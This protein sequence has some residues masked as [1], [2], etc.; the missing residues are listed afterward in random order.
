MYRNGA[1]FQDTV[2]NL[3]I[4]YPATRPA[5]NHL[6]K[7]PILQ[8]YTPANTYALYQDHCYT[9]GSMEDHSLSRQK[10]T[11]ILPQEIDEIENMTRGQSKYA[12]WAE[13]RRMRVTESR[14]D[15]IVNATD[16]KDFENN[17]AQSIVNPSTFS[18]P[19][20]HH[21]IEE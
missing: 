16:R 20:T 4:G 6:E 7:M 2:R 13:G 21:G 15:E 1:H 5:E 18:R 12:T 3:S 17:I 14:V 11:S 19:A 10:I 8:L 9:E